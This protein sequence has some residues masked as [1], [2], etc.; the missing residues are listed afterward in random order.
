MMPKIFADAARMSQ[1][2]ARQ[3][4][5]EHLIKV[6]YFDCIIENIHQVKNSLLLLDNRYSID[7]TQSIAE[8]HKLISHTPYD[9]VLLNES[10]MVVELECPIVV[11]PNYM[12]KLSRWKLAYNLDELIHETF[13]SNYRPPQ[14]ASPLIAE[15]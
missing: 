2:V 14:F 4:G 10:Q 15:V 11:I 7:T 5:V 8:A 9:A 12:Y 1:L 13:S 6:L 3:I